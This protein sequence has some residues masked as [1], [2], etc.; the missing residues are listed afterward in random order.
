MGGL[1]M[2]GQK[3]L[4]RTRAPATHIHT[5]MHT[6]TYYIRDACFDAATHTTSDRTTGIR[7]LG[8]A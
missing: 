6:R 1:G 4:R 5:H 3:A 8:M 2:G 7:C